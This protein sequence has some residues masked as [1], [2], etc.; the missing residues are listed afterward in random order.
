MNEGVSVFY[1]LQSSR[2]NNY[3][4]SNIPFSLTSLLNPL[5][6]LFVHGSR[7]QCPCLDAKTPFINLLFSIIGAYL[8]NGN[9]PSYF[10]GSR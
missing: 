7:S 1:C 6:S 4:P 9:F 5:G 8:Y 10:G 2:E 3:P